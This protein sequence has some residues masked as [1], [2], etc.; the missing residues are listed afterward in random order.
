ML[1]TG[2]LSSG[3]LAGGEEG[4]CDDYAMRDVEEIL[5]NKLSAHSSHY[6]DYTTRLSGVE[7]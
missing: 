5:I 2:D 4:D 7:N 3:I 1:I 6:T